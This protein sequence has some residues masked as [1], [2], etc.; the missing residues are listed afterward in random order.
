MDENTRERFAPLFEPRSI[1]VVGASATGITPGNEFIRHSR[2]LGY[3]GKIFPL[4]PKAETVEGL[5]CYRS[6]AEIGE[7]VDYAYV[8]IAAEQIPALLESAAGRLRYAQVMSSGFGEVADGRE[9]EA[10]LLAAARAGGIRLLGPNCLGVHSPRGGITFVGGAAGE[11]GSIGIASQSGGLAV[12]IILRGRTRGLGFSGVATLGNSVDLGPADL[13]E[14]YLSDAETRAIGC[15]VEDVKDGRRFFDVLRAS[16]GA[17]P[18]VLLIGGQ[19]AQGRQAAASHTGSLASDARIW[20][21]LARQTGAV[22]TTTL[23]EFLDV[24]LAFQALTPRRDR[25]TR[26]AV[27]FGNGGGTSV[28]AADAF[29]RAGI[30]VAPMDREAIS[31][32]EA[33]NLPPGTSVANP[34]DTP[35]GT[36][37]QEEGRVAE[38]ILSIVF[39]AAR[40]DA[41]VMH[42]NLP[43]FLTATDQRVDVVANLMQAAL[44]V[45]AAYPGRAHFVLV[46]RSDGTAASDERKRLYRAEAARLGIP[47]YDEMTNAATALGAVA[48]FER[49]CGMRR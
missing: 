31:R 47:V 32:L 15:Y 28:L 6:F 22:V 24:L 41:I 33:L 1:V 36:L 30:T 14:F 40:P 39:E 5:R 46:L 2:A 7:I 43:V 17:K 9:R 25:R 35:A 42:V 44:R 27:L 10:R 18:V 23:E 11:R 12:D 20:A 8:A 34:I 38:R 13:L 29:A 4:H 49:F 21:G 45:R 26:A 48:A 16:R 3:A 19:T 37:R